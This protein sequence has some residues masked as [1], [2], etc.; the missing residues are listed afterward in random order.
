MPAIASVPRML[1]GSVTWEEGGTSLE[2][3]AVA[4]ELAGSALVK[5]WLED[6][7][8][9]EPDDDGDDEALTAEKLDD[10]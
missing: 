9:L 8:G 4:V 7:T 5:A 2:R 1:D 3:L 10:D 6:A